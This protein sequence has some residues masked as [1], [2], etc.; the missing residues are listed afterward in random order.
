MSSRPSQLRQVVLSH[1]QQAT[2]PT[3]SNPQ[4][5]FTEGGPNITSGVG[6]LSVGTVTLSGNGA[7]NIGTNAAMTVTGIV[8]GA[9][10][11]AWL[12]R[13][14]TRIDRPLIDA[15]RVFYHGTLSVWV[16]VNLHAS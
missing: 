11:W 10:Q 4:F 7:F 13:M 2:Y 16:K 8:S 9:S 15:G 3:S 12:N 5:W 1:D 14:R 6:T